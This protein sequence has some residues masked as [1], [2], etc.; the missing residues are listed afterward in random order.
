MLQVPEFEHMLFEEG[1]HLIKFYFSISRKENMKSRV[2][3]MKSRVSLAILRFVP[4]WIII[5]ALE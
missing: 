1:I 2:S 3:N 5:L 4:I